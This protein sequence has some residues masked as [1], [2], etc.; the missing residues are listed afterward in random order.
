M[1]SVSFRFKPGAG[2]RHHDRAHPSVQSASRHRRRQRQ[3]WSSTLRCDDA[4]IIRV[5]TTDDVPHRQGQSHAVG[6]I[7]GGS[8]LLAIEKRWHKSRH[9]SAPARRSPS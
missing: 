2:H 6:L 7:T 9:S 4:D 3:H 8:S 1:D 5:A